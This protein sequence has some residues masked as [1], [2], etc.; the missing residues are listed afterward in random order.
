[1]KSAKEIYNECL[2]KHDMITYQ[3]LAIEAMK[4]Y[5]KQAID[6]QI[7]FL[8]ENGIEQDCYPNGE[9]FVDYESVKNCER[10]ELN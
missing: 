10:I 4:E 3:D 6:A 5:A 7:S 8:I 1:M 2:K 9:C